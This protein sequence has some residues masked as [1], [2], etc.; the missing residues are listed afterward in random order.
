MVIPRMLPFPVPIGMGVFGEP[1]TAVIIALIVGLLVGTTLSLILL[2]T[3]LST[4]GLST[5]ENHRRYS[6]LR[7]VLLTARMTIAGLH[8]LRSNWRNIGLL[9]CCPTKFPS[10]WNYSL[11][12]GFTAMVLT[13]RFF[14]LLFFIGVLILRKRRDRQNE[15]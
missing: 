11:R 7:L 10:H 2:A 5:L 6:G 9:Y 1:E 14:V 12:G 8:A 4:T 15:G 3:R 13:F